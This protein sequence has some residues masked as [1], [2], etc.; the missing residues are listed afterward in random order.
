MSATRAHHLV[1]RGI[2]QDVPVE[3]RG[4]PEVLRVG[5]LVGGDDDGSGGGEAVERLAARPLRLAELDVACGDVVDDGVAP[6][7]VER[8]A[9]VHSARGP[10][11]DHAELGLV[12]DLGR[13]VAGPGGGRAVRGERVRP[14]REHGHRGLGAQLQLGG[15]GGVVRADGEHLRRAQHGRRVAQARR[16]ERARRCA[17]AASRPP[18]ERRRARRGPRSM[19]SCRSRGASGMTSSRKRADSPRTTASRGVVWPSALRCANFTVLGYRAS[20]P[21]GVRGVQRTGVDAP[22][23]RQS[24]A[25]APAARQRCIE[26]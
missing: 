12:V 7:V 24:H 13:E 3:V 16:P 6:H 19:R 23:R 1:G 11:D 26:A 17:S 20:R 9:R 4:E 5:D 22:P 25:C 10:A 21:G 18:R 15:V 8:I 2:L 14:E